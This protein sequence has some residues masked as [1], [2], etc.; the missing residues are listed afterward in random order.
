[1][2]KKDIT[3]PFWPRLTQTKVKS[4]YIQC[5]WDKWID[6]DDLEEEGGKGLDG[7]PSKMESKSY[8]IF[9]F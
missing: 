5:D 3:S 6:E 4:Q 1:M 9:R 8:F 7:V 2:V